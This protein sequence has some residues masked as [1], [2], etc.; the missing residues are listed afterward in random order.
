MTESSSTA[1][2]DLFSAAAVQAKPASDS[3]EPRQKRPLRIEP[4]EMDEGTHERVLS[5]ILG[6]GDRSS[7]QQKRWTGR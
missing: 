6:V 3:D 2:H 1:G 7:R 5:E 4:L